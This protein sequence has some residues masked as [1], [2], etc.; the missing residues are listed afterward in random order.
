MSS[1]KDDAFYRNITRRHNGWQLRKD[2]E[3]YGWY[4]NVED[5]LFD[6]DRLEQV[7]WDMGIFVELPEIPNPYYHINLPPYEEVKSSFI[8]YLPE[9]WRVQK[10]INGK[11]CYFGTYDSFEEAEKR[12]DDLLRKRWL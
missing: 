2:G 7:D 1:L 11:M 10:R 4:E 6:R 5:A 12:R 8:Q 3:H 9:K